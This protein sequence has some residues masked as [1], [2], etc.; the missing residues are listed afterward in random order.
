MGALTP[1][2]PEQ[3]RVT[4]R[5]F[6]TAKRAEHAHSVGPG[7]PGFGCTL[8]GSVLL[9]DQP[10]IMAGTTENA[11]RFVGTAHAPHSWGLVMAS[12]W[13]VVLRA[14]TDSESHGGAAQS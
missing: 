2:G 11:A 3:A 1:R 5:E 12:S 13:A 8:V 9:V 6:D 7:Q 10:R 14:R 4:T